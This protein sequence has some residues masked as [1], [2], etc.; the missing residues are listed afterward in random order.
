MLIR[1]ILLSILLPYSSLSLADTP[2]ELTFSTLSRGTA[3]RDLISES[4]IRE[5]YSN[6]G[7]KVNIVSLPG[8]RA[9]IEANKG[10][11]D[12]ELRRS[13]IDIK[14]YPN[15]IKVD[16]PVN[17]IDMCVFGITNK[18]RIESKSD[19]NQLTVGF[20][21]GGQ[22]SAELAMHA[23]SQVSVNGGFGQLLGLLKLN[24]LDLA[25][26]N[27]QILKDHI[28]ENKIEDI[29]IY[30]PPLISKKLYHYIHVKHK[31]LLARVKNEIE[32]TREKWLA[33]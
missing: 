3:Q 29:Y 10:R 32:L 17:S 28:L 1:L 19:L 21:N 9:L 8:R 18:Y 24:R 13:N 14:K 7:I 27:C 16:S 25:I 30:Q 11:F 23:K 22:L 4:I 15:L 31:N 20:Q 5:A 2:S 6:L 26:S 12:G 33:H